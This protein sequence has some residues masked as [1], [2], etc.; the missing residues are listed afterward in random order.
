M[1]FRITSTLFIIITLGLIVFDQL[2]DIPAYIYFGFAL[3]YSAL[4]FWGTIALSF[5]FFGPAKCKGE[6]N[7]KSVAITFDD[8][9]EP[10]AT[11][12]VLTI[13]K[14][15]DA[16]ATF[17]C[18]GKNVKDN[19]D[20]IRQIDSEGH[21]IGNHSF[22]HRSWFDLQPRRKMMTEIQNTNA[23]IAEATG[24]QPRFF[25]PPYG[26]INPILAS[27]IQKTRMVNVGWSVRSFDTVARDKNK[28]MERITKRLKGG[29]IIL[30]HDRCKLTI[31]IL[32]DLLMFITKS[33][34]KVESL[35][36]MIGEKA[37]V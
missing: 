4:F 2:N 37:Y 15:A 7:S 24:K 10:E 29:D 27:E 3:I 23:I 12:L 20:L 16:K 35:D 1:N 17:F 13:L 6:S 25:R 33:G 5:Q 26:V 8:G 36:K 11:H 9:P 14:T 34:L 28:L 21:L 30:F 18:I 22:Y 31:E 19:P 32:P